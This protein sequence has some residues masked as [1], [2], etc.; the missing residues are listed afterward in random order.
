MTALRDAAMPDRVFL[1]SPAHCGGLRANMLMSPRARFSLACR[2]RESS[3]A[4]LGEV[5]SFLSGLYFRGKLAY[6]RRFARAPKGMSGV[7]VITTSA[8]LMD[9]DA[10][11][12]LATLQGFGRV[13]IH[14]D[15]PLYRRPLER[16]V[17]GLARTIPPECDVVLL[18]SIATAKYKDVLVEVL[19]RRLRFPTEF[20]GRGDMSRGG[21]L[22]RAARAGTELEYEPVV[23][24]M[25]H[26]KRAPKLPR[27]PRRAGT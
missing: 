12:T 11:V 8:G 4:P 23:G 21:L 1:L 22:L 14:E 19:G 18:G 16:A 20:V 5:F 26:G 10:P 9:A 6:G 24:A 27:L 2:L 25:L 3:G 13:D 15:D 7:H 17:R